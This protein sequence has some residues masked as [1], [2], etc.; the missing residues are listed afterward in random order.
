MFIIFEVREADE[1]QSKHAME[2]LF[3][4]ERPVLIG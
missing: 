4:E 2:S 3:E 1:K